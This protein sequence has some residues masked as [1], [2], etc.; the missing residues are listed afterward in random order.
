MKYATLVK[1]T[2]GW[3]KTVQPSLH[4][5]DVSSKGVRGP[6]LLV[7]SYSLIAG[8]V[9]LALEGKPVHLRA[10]ERELASATRRELNLLGLSAAPSYRQLRYRLELIQ[11]TCNQAKNRD[12]SVQ[13]L[14][15]LLVPPSAGPAGNTSTWAVDTHLFGAWANQYTKDTSDPDAT[16]RRMD[17]AKHKAR[18]VLGYQLTAVV[19][20][21]G[22]EVCDRMRLITANANDSLA[23]VDA[24]K[25]MRDDGFKVHRVLA[26][27]GFSQQPKGFLNPL[28]DAGVHLTFDLKEGDV[29]VSGTF[30]GALVIDGWL[31]S[32]AI[33]KGLRHIR[34]PGLNATPEEKAKFYELM[35][36]RDAYAFSP[37]A[38]PGAAGGRLASPAFRKKLRCKVVK[39]SAPDAAPTCRVAHGID[40]ACALRTTT[41]TYES[42]PRTY[43]WPAWGT[44]DWVQI[45]KKRSAVERF[46]GHLQ[47]DHGPAFRPGRFRLRRMPKVAV[48]TA[49]FVIATNIALV[50]KA[51]ARAVPIPT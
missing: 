1:L 15:D 23:A 2:D 51:A 34:K 49:A 22:A 39:N 6:K 43:Q 40:E 7:G 13:Q 26:D 16:W 9:Y 45:Y 21:E 12:E 36:K 5:L 10:L 50:E 25:R 38:T 8:L 14:L 28:R 48:V 41:F 47:S 11:R 27:R 17:T 44:A 29:G 20:T 3:G 31:H 30:K 42:A 37:H 4:A 46:F 35:A 33:P 19:R 18:A 24:I 32:P